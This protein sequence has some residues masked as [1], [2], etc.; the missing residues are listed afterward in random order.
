LLNQVLSNCVFFAFSDLSLL[1]TGSL[2]FSL[3]AKILQLS[4][5]LLIFCI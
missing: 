1:K 5:A 2:H 4:Q 3:K